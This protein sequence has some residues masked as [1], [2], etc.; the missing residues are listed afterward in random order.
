MIG[1]YLLPP[2]LC[3][4]ISHNIAELGIYTKN[5]QK[6]IQNIFITVDTFRKKLNCCVVNLSL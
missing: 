5:I 6:N 2:I 1:V 4:I 3:V